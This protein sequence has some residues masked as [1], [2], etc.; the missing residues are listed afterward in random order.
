MLYKKD[1]ER[2]LRLIIAVYVDD[3]LISGREIDIREFKETFKK[4]CTITN[5]GKAKRHLG[6]WYEWIKSDKE[7]I[8]KMHMDDIARK[9]VKEYEKMTNETMKEP[10]SPGYA[11]MKIL[12]SEI[13]DKKI[14]EQSKY[15]LMV[16]KVM[17]L[18]NKSDPT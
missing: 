9:I 10:N 6:M 11:N 14:Y 1:E 3:V 18:V 5:L 16:G 13:D 2:K 4:T 7:S 15:R 12:K 17:Y 8:T